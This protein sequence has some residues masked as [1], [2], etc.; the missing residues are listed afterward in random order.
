[1]T[2]ANPFGSKQPLSH[3]DLFLLNQQCEN[4]SREKQSMLGNAQQ[5]NRM[6]DMTPCR[7]P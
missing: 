1:M 5:Q 4:T 6:L 3:V 7:C 2:E